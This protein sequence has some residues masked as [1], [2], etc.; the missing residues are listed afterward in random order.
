MIIPLLI[1][2]GYGLSAL[3][4]YL[5][6]MMAPCRPIWHGRGFRADSRVGGAQRRCAPPVCQV[7]QPPGCIRPSQA[8]TPQSGHAGDAAGAAM[9]AV[10]AGAG[11]VDG[12]IS[13][14]TSKLCR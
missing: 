9:N 11:A 7:I 10:A 4:G 6:S 14:W 13:S 1:A 12:L 5:A 8:A 2:L 3:R